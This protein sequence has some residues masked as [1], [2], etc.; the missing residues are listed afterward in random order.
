MALLPKPLRDLL[1]LLLQPPLRGAWFWP[2]FPGDGD[3]DDGFGHSVAVEGDT[4]VIGAYH[5]E[6]PN[7]DAAGSAY[8]FT[9]SNEHWTGKQKLFA[10]DGDTKDVFG[11][12]V[13][14]EEGIALVG[15]KIDEDPNGEYAGSAYVFMK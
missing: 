3:G 6:D 12:G 9:R 14:L 13:A 7:G 4:A 2:D 8:V 11:W 15:A 10:D 1:Q 5:D